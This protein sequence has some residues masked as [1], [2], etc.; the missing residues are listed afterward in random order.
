MISVHHRLTVPLARFKDEVCAT[1]DE[2]IERPDRFYRFVG[3]GEPVQ[4]IPHRRQSSAF[5]QSDLI[6][7]QGTSAVSV[8]KNIISLALV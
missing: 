6:T 3:V 5:L 4:D 2:R 8:W 7:V 1:D